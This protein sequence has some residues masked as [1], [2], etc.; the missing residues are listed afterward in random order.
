MGRLPEDTKTAIKV[1]IVDDS[2]L[3]RE[4]L[5]D[6][7]SDEIGLK[8]VGLA[9][10]GIEAVCLAKE[11]KPDVI[12]MDIRM[13]EME[14]F[15]AIEIIMSENPVPILVV[16]DFDNSKNAFL[17]ISKGA[18]DIYPKKDIGESNSGEYAAKLKTLSRVKVI[19]HIKSA[20]RLLTIQKSPAAVQLP[21]VH[22]APKSRKNGEYDIVAIASSTGGPGALVSVLSAFKGNCSV[23]VVVAQHIN[24]EFVISFIEWL[25]SS[26]SL[27]VKIAVDGE[28]LRPGTV[29]F[30]PPGKNIRISAAK[31]VVAAER[32]PGDIYHPSCNLLLSSVGEAYGGR[33]IGVILTGM[34]ED[35]AEGLGFI[36]R[37]GGMTI[38]Q[39]EESSIIFGMP[40]VAA[41][42][43][44]ADL[45]LPLVK[46]GKTIF[47]ALLVPG[48]EK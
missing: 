9:K 15:E 42:K 5:V 43:G 11:L 25:A 23:P 22:P 36:H 31:K 46:I 13:P 24:D 35:G 10:N 33:S 34:G 32:M 3:M 27:K 39:D 6:L 17:A 38:A 20:P 41:A 1:L 30:A 37:K 8:V 29:Y 2:P 45:V 19:R 7:L 12:S 44:Y 4:M 47:D 28:N 48:N 16:T 21:P 26:V 40:A 18:L 14:G